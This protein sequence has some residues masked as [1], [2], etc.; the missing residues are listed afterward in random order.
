MYTLLI[1][2]KLAVPTGVAPAE[3]FFINLFVREMNMPCFY[4][5]AISYYHIIICN[6]WPLANIYKQKK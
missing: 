2:I 3:I 4:Y 5:L 1:I 6:H